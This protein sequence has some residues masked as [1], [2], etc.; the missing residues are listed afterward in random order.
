[1]LLGVSVGL[2]AVNAKT[3]T[4]VGFGKTPEEVK[5]RPTL[6]R[7]QVDLPSA[8]DRNFV[9]A[10]ILSRRG[11]SGPHLYDR[12]D[13]THLNG[14]G[15]PISGVFNGPAAP[16]AITIALPNGFRNGLASRFQLFVIQIFPEG[17]ISAPV[18]RSKASL[19]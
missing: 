6:P 10:R 1:M 16:I 18:I 2:R 15:G 5:A 13:Q 4:M 7:L 12:F 11:T 17:S 14:T 19:L 3:H 9:H 8:S